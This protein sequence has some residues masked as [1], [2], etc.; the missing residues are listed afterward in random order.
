MEIA[1]IGGKSTL[2]FEFLPGDDYNHRREGVPRPVSALAGPWV[3]IGYLLVDVLS[4]CLNAFCVFYFRWLADSPGSLIRS[5]PAVISRD[6]ALQEYAGFLLLYV[7]LIVLF[8]QNHHLYRTLRTRSALDESLAVAKAVTYATL[9]LTTFI[10]LS[11]VQTVSR[12]V[13]GF[14][15]LLNVATLATW[16]MCKRRVVARRVA[17]GQGARNVL[18]VGAGRVGR[19]LARHF[20]ENKQLGYVVKGFLDQNHHCDSRLLGRIEDLAQV[21]QREF[22]DEVFITTP[23]ERQVVRTVLREARRHRLDVKV[24]PELY[25]GLGW[26]APLSYVGDFPVMALHW[27]PIPVL[28]LF[29]KRLMD[30]AFSSLGLVALSPLLAAVALAIALDSRGPIL[31]P[32]K[33]VGKKGRTFVCYKFRSMVPDADFL[34]ESL[35]H[36]NERDGPFFKISCDPR[37]TRLG[38]SLRKYSLD[39]LPQLWNVLKGD[40]SLVGPRPH[41]LDDYEQY[42]LEHLR[43]LDVKPGLTGLWQVTARQDPSFQENMALDLQYIQ[44]WDVWLDLRILWRTVGAVLEGAG[45]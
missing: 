31:Y 30:I 21:A 19:A 13:V 41:P 24:V 44:N 6:L 34:K 25:D 14:S 20:E 32:S 9:L 10:Y 2:A 16:R 7:V 1:G 35:R 28:G 40:M 4:V 23:S 29:F 5:A 45:K 17:Q 38:R 22:A 37:I 39:E 15:G 12:L 26:Q 18:I 43:R 27:E 11:G 33:R 42:H 3:E 36:L 8:C